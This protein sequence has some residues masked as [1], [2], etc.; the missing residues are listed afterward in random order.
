MASK[1]NHSKITEQIIQY[2]KDS[3][4]SGEWTVG[5]KIP[6]ENQLKDSLGVSRSS[7]RAAI[8]Y[9]TG[10]GVLETRHGKGTYLLDS[11]VDE[12]T[13]SDG[14]ITSE[15]CKDIEKVLEFRRIVETEACF[16]ATQ[17]ATSK[18]LEEL[19]E[20]LDIM[21]ANEGKR[22][23]FV[24][25]DMR[26][27]SLICKASDNPILEKTMLK[28]FEETVKNHKQMNTIFGYKDGIYYHSRILEAMQKGDA[29][30]AKKYMY[31]H[32]QNAINKIEQDEGVQYIQK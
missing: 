8:Q 23:E 12:N 26:F 24:M 29:V 30:Q 17:K 16:M 27:H 18:L 9:L 25:A 3:I 1:I 31:E 4:N 13:G 6:S 2:C 32:L 14:K 20:C 10:L 5:E 15:D 19:K 11:Q 22:N 21:S 28:V 7:I